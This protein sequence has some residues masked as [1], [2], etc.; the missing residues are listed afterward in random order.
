MAKEAAP[1]ALDIDG[2]PETDE[3]ADEKLILTSTADI[4]RQEE[5]THGGGGGAGDIEKSFNKCP[6]LVTTC[7]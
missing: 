6:L 3:V 2:P 4:L 1:L 5:R 7:K